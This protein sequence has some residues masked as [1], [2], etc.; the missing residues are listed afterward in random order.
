MGYE[1]NA[2]DHDEGESDSDELDP[3]LKY[4]NF[5]SV[6]RD[7]LRPSVATLDKTLI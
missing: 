6:E 5:Q 1:A 4:P 3:S 7:Q 2:R